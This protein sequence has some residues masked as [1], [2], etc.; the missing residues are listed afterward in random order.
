[1]MG[2]KV[3]QEKMFYNFSLDKKVSEDHF[4][5]KVEKVVDLRFVREL[6]SPYY[7]HTGQ[8]SVDPEVLFKMM[9]IG[10]FYGI[11][12]ERRLA[13]ELSLNLAY[14]W[15]CGYDLDEET[16]NHSVISK[17]RARYG[18]EVFEEFF[19]KILSQ[20]IQVGLVKCEKVFMDSTL[21]EAN[22]SMK[23]VVPRSEAKEIRLTPEE[24][25]KKLFRENPVTDD[26]LTKEN[27]RDGETCPT[28]QSETPELGVPVYDSQTTPETKTY[29]QKHISNLDYVS[30]TDPDSSIV[31]RTG[32]GLKLYYKQHFAVD[33]AHRV[34]TAVCVT[35]GSVDDSRMFKELL[36]R[37]PILPKEVCGD[38]KYGTA[39][40]FHYAFEKGILPSMPR[41][42]RPPVKKGP[43][44]W[45][46][47]R[48]SY[49]ETEEVYLCPAGK[50]LRKI[51][52]YK[53]SQQWAYRS[54]ASECKMCAFKNQCLGPK[55]KV[56]NVSR[57]IHQEILEKAT[58]Y[59]KT[60]AAQV[61]IQERK[62]YAEW[63]LAEA[64]SLHGLRRARCRGKWKMSVQALLTASVQN[65]KRLVKHWEGV[66]P[67]EGYKTIRDKLCE[68]FLT[69]RNGALCPC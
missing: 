14:L 65:I 60:P 20:C 18:K 68:P 47:E 43:N 56:R 17:A 26:S 67:S 25:V 39:E 24:Y 64:K 57:H 49:D 31:S 1:M 50:R 16:P 35:P 66:F 48:F 15:Y 40:N 28:S 13:E 53:H 51:A 45:G 36:E 55:S 46:R 6:T 52:F 8:P 11:T 42:M 23:S 69:L 30:K 3:Y 34:I 22:A 37:Q 7:S 19:Q 61:T 58:E 12:S 4:L 38:S 63:A 29:R 5:R 21:I 59:L 44:Q 10:Y 41:W 32:W 54:K 27:N 33:K 2:I 9:L 62:I